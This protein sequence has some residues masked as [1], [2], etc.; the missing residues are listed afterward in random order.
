MLK[1]VSSAVGALKRVRPFIPKETAIQ[2]YNALIVPYFDYW[3]PVWDCL[4][5][6]L[7]DKFQKLQN[8]AARVI[9]NLPFDTNSNHLLT[10][11]NWERLS[12]RPK[13]RKA[14]MMCKTMNGHAPDY[15]Q[16]LFTQYHSNY[17]LRLT[18]RENW[19]CQ[20][21]ELS[22]FKRTSP[23]AGPNYG[24]TCPVA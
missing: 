5:G 24:I 11:L 22:Y 16:R 2:I 12:I 21:R 1:K 7:R 17:N 20:N 19:L 4:N 15:L 13:K 10:T 14:L 3:S 9:A 8:R 6:Y 23:I 18:L